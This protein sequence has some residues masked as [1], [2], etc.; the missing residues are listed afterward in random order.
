MVKRA[1]TISTILSGAMNINSQEQFRG[2]AFFKFY[3]EFKDTIWDAAFGSEGFY[4]YCMDTNE[5]WFG[6]KTYGHKL[7]FEINIDYFKFPLKRIGFSKF[8][9]DALSL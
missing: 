7:T 2:N 9:Y 6:F 8:G 5:Q 3:V 4:I 1:F